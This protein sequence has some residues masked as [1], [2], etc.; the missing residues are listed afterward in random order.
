MTPHHAAE[1]V[2]L[3][4][5]LYPEKLSSEQLGLAREEFEHYPRDLVEQV[6][7]EYRKMHDEP[8]IAAL[9]EILKGKYRMHDYR[10]PAGAS[11]REK[12]EVVNELDAL[13]DKIAAIEPAKR[14]RLKSIA[15]AKQEPFVV[16]KL[17]NKDP[18]Q[19]TFL[20]SLVAQ[21][22]GIGKPK[23]AASM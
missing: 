21:E 8:G 10:P 20:L 7:K 13:K 1:M 15:L 19:D 18:L 2:R 9:F 11:K 3:L 6:L 16:A 17:A 22:A 12:K 14:D 23:D 4:I 5:G